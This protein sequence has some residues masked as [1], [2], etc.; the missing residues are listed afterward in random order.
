MSDD[1]WDDAELD[2]LFSD[3][4]PEALLAEARAIA[5][6]QPNFASD[7]DFNDLFGAE[8]ELAPEAVMPLLDLDEL[9]DMLPATPT[10]DVP[11][12]PAPV[13]EPGPLAAR[14]SRPKAVAPGLSDAKPVVQEV[15]PA[16]MPPADDTPN[17]TYESTKPHAAPESPTISTVAVP[18]ALLEPEDSVLEDNSLQDRLKSASTKLHGPGAEA[19][20]TD[21][22]DLFAPLPPN[23]SSPSRYMVREDLG[24][25]SSG[26]T[27]RLS[28]DVLKIQG[29]VAQ[30]SGLSRM[31]RAFVITRNLAQDLQQRQDLETGLR[32]SIASLLPRTTAADLRKT[33][34]IVYSE[35]VG[36]GPIL[37][38]WRDDS[39]TEIFVDAYNKVSVEVD[40][41]I[42]PTDISFRDLN[43]AQQI[44]RDLAQ[45]VS[46]RAL[47]PVDC[48]V[49][50]KLPNAR[51]NFA[52]GPIV[53]SHISISL[54][55]AKPLL[56]MD[57]LVGIHALSPEMRQFLHD[58]VVAKAN[59]LVS[60]GTG[61]GKTTIIN[62]VS[63]AIPPGERVITIEDSRE[64]AIDTP[65]L[66]QMVTK[67]SASAEDTTRVT[68]QDLLVN[69]LRMRPDRIIVGEIRESEDARVMFQ[70]AST[71]HD[72]TMTTVHASSVT[73]AMIRCADLLRSGSGGM[74]Q[75][76]SRKRVADTFDVVIQ[77]TRRAGRR[78]I[79]SIAVVLHDESTESG[80]IQL[81][82]LFTGALVGDTPVFSQVGHMQVD[83]YLGAR[84]ADVGIN[85]ARWA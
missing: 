75:T 65:F 22:D 66:I 36:L 78:F 33:L 18:E 2:A 23:E 7:D 61:V 29:F 5:A 44:A 62:A 20:S 24:V 69:S 76:M 6:G 71:G 3:P 46:N 51:I 56:S 9:F 28:G 32:G 11:L 77:G 60:G 25:T 57:G 82:E 41:R 47:S 54:R 59:V 37:P 64:L 55:K 79:S 42:L 4:D 26:D 52:Y 16:F 15:P 49:T 72:G 63:E 80:D 50:A 74:D 53:D 45:R 67:E 17:N 83:S 19:A 8:E 48:L 43:H 84:L 40:G 30:D 10:K 14:P 1:T 81:L 70:A 13:A 12:A 68:Q 21:F 38:L 85:P 35:A 39:V 27:H 31:L 73:G 58:V 34:D